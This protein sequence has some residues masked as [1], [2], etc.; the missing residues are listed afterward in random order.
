MA[1]PA[2]KDWWDKA[3]EQTGR[4]VGGTLGGIYG[5]LTEIG[6]F[7]EGIFDTKAADFN[8]LKSFPEFNKHLKDYAMGRVPAP[9]VE[10]TETE[11]GLP[12]QPTKVF[13]K[14]P[15]G[16]YKEETELQK[17][18]G[19]GFK[20]VVGGV[21]GPNAPKGQ[22][23]DEGKYAPTPFYQAAKRDLLNI[24]EGL[25]GIISTAT[26]F[27]N[28]ATARA[29]QK[30]KEAGRPTGGFLGEAFA[31]GEAGFETGRDIA[32]GFLG[33][34]AIL[35]GG[36][37]E[38]EEGKRM[39]R[40]QPITYALNAMPILSRISGAAKSGLLSRVQVAEL[41]TRIAK[42]GIQGVSTIDDLNKHLQ[43]ITDPVV[44]AAEESRVAPTMAEAAQAATRVFSKAAPV[45]SVLKTGL[46]AA[47]QVAGKAPFVAAGYSLGGPVG[48]AVGAALT[49]TPMLLNFMKGT[50]TA[51]AVRKKTAG[52]KRKFVEPRTYETSEAAMAGEE[53]LRTEGETAVISQK[54]QPAAEAA[55]KGFTDSF[56]EKTDQTL[57]EA[58]N[59]VE[60]AQ[61]TLEE[62]NSA[63][64]AVEQVEPLTPEQR[65]NVA[66]R[67]A[68]LQRAVRTAEQERTN[69]VNQKAN[70]PN[71]VISPELTEPALPDQ[72]PKIR[73]LKVDFA[74]PENQRVLLQTQ[75]AIRG[76]ELENV[77]DTP[78]KVKQ[79]ASNLVISQNTP[80]VWLADDALRERV[81]SKFNDA[82]MNTERGQKLA[83]TEGFGATTD[84]L[85]PDQRAVLNN[86]LL[87]ISNKA[88][89]NGSPTTLRA[90]IYSV[91]NPLIQ[92]KLITLKD[93]NVLEQAIGQKPLEVL[94]REAGGVDYNPTKPVLTRTLQT[95][96]TG[97][98]ERV[99]EPSV[100]KMKEMPV[101]VQFQ[102]V[103]DAFKAGEKFAPLAIDFDPQPL[104]DTLR[105]EALETTDPTFRGNKAYKD[106]LRQT[107][108]TL[109]T[110]KTPK[111]EMG[112][113]VR[114]APSV[115]GLPLQNQYDYNLNRIDSL[116]ETSRA[117]QAMKRLS[118][119]YNPM[120]GLGN[121]L[122]N[123][124]VRMM[125][126]GSPLPM[127]LIRQ[128][129][130]RLV[131]FV[132]RKPK[133]G[134]T[135]QDELVLRAVPAR[136]ILSAAETGA[137]EGLYAIEKT[138]LGKVV[139]AAYN[140][141]DAVFKLD[142]ATT[143]SRNLLDDLPK[144]P[145]GRMAQLPV[146]PDITLSVMRNGDKYTFINPEN[147][148][149]LTS[150]TLESPS[151]KRILGSSVKAVVDSLYPDVSQ[152]PEY[153]ATLA[154][155]RGG[156][157]AK[158]ASAI[159]FAPF[160]SYVIK[161]SDNPWKKGILSTLIEGNVSSPLQL[162]LTLRSPLPAGK[163][164]SQFTQT[165][166][167]QGSRYA[168]S[169]GLINSM[170]ARFQDLSGEEKEQLRMI[171]AFSPSKQKPL[172]FA[173]L[174]DLDNGQQ[175]PR[176]ISPTF[177]NFWSYTD[178][179]IRGFA[180]ASQ[181]VGK[182]VAKAAENDEEMKG[183]KVVDEFTRRI[184]EGKP[185][186]SA[187]ALRAAGVSGGLLLPAFIKSL[188]SERLGKQDITG[189]DLLKPF[190]I[191]GRAMI[192]AGE[193]TGA[194]DPNVNFTRPQR[195][196]TYGKIMD[197][198]I[199]S[200]LTQEQTPEK[201]A[202]FLNK[203]YEEQYKLMVEPLLN[204]AALDPDRAVEY[205]LEAIAMAD[206]LK[207]TIM[208]RRESFNETIMKLG[209][210]DYIKEDKLRFKKPK[211]RAVPTEVEETIDQ[212]ETGAGGE[213]PK[214][215]GMEPTE[216]PPVP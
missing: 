150:G 180:W 181:Q 182:A 108:D 15:E 49:A 172:I 142:K 61:K 122:G 18:E 41:N 153:F 192:F 119:I 58:Q 198:I 38:G 32:G 69:L 93:L 177:T 204:K 21:L 123:A 117:L 91:L 189:R 175:V 73:Q 9:Y 146:G 157:G 90:S 48:A 76:T 53:L 66:V 194:L 159:V 216:P 208:L 165:A 202:T 188:E 25:G 57:S 42:L 96:Q 169:R 161:A 62:H 199:G 52:V 6:D 102:K 40:E 160:M 209:I 120:T 132:K 140:Y 164:A 77:F 200:Q 101:G 68:E 26:G 203:F 154:Q 75:E 138:G 191:L 173:G 3:K 193:Q 130:T 112:K 31:A 97:L 136:D 171:Y 45:S 151:V 44:R 39:I 30:N 84:V 56:V 133:G 103:V 11:E 55:K 214:F 105:K 10:A 206:A 125:D 116:S 82:L 178:E 16:K 114:V 36:L 78:D 98:R 95:L 104:I 201:A 64:Q 174:M 107:A 143:L 137:E 186:T 71:V 163:A 134:L 184:L 83:F 70:D 34:P 87:D 43:T 113:G 121:Y 196:N 167:G 51:E 72:P 59:K 158:V 1:E 35:I 29:R 124:M 28:E 109:E 213:P 118:T 23:T 141:G 195:A 135:L 13:V 65:Q 212:G 94:V 139:R 185:P 144:V 111:V 215:E 148:K 47:G 211:V 7:G 50:K 33:M 20:R 74:E 168:A 86:A 24:G 5:A 99:I 152:L 14:T 92:Q 54:L 183:D 100:L 190:G 80:L 12:L 128:Q 27:E 85:T 60:Q 106:F 156:V 8:P 81:I 147:G 170:G 166:L 79:F 210:N 4:A 63:V 19:S 207:Q 115:A 89:N 176:F 2:E 131:D 37:K 22:K 88:Y 17:A 149:I 46:E 129:A 127:E 187:D 197:V 179:T 126:A 155:G 145:E 67:T 110:L 162:P 205:E